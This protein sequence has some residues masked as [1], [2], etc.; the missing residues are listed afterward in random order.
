[1]PEQKHYHARGGLTSGVNLVSP[2]G[3]AGL[4][5]QEEPSYYR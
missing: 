1:M 3:R 5:S 2:V 4:T